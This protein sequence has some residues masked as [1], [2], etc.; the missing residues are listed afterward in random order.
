M[1]EPNKTLNA[2]ALP[3]E[4]EGQ[5]RARLLLQPNIHA[6]CAMQAI[7]ANLAKE[8][9]L[10][11]LV[12]ALADQVK[13]VNGGDLSRPESMLV[14]QAHTLDQLF[15]RLA[16]QA[17][18]NIGHYPDTVAVYLKLALKAQAQCAR[19]VEVLNEVKNPRPLAFVAQA[20]VTTGPQQVNNGVPAR[21]E[22]QKAQTE[23][24]QASDGEFL[25]AGTAGAAG[26][27]NQTLAAVDAQHRAA[28]A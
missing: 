12:D 9:P 20:N 26:R 7:E 25:D 4:T 17:A 16:R 6:A 24:L 21:A 18:A 23:L 13:A 22:K 19:T 27:G 14:S 28:H 2:A 5:A 11:D 1:A 10:T 3:G 8:V 15:N